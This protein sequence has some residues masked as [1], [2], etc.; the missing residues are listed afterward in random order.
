MTT[1]P[2]IK[3]IVLILCFQLKKWGVKYIM[4]WFAARA[5]ADRVQ[6]NMLCMRLSE[7]I[8]WLVFCVWYGLRSR[9]Q[10][11]AEAPHDRVAYFISLCLHFFRVF[12]GSTI[13]THSLQCRYSSI[14]WTT[15]RSP[16]MP[17]R[18]LV[19]DVKYIYVVE[20]NNWRLAI[21]WIHALTITDWLMENVNWLL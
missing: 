4:R 14:D 7:K 10:K 8:V 17:L 12:N 6:V 11:I 2:Y 9:L 5:R 18:R 16:G 15:S 1:F 3:K 19:D 20:N 21:L 13:L